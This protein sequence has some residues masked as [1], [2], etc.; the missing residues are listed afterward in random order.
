MSLNSSLETDVVRLGNTHLSDT[1]CRIPFL[2]VRLE[3]VMDCNCV[4]LMF[5]HRV[6][7]FITA[8]Y[9]STF[10]PRIFLQLVCFIVLL[11]KLCIM[12]PSVIYSS[13]WD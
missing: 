3:A 4:C 8:V 12:S 7:I 6:I 1:R 5:R 9:Y 2:K 13:E 10:D 11:S